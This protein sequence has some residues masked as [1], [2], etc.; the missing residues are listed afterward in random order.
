MQHRDEAAGIKDREP[1]PGQHY[2][3][4][5][6]AIPGNR[7]PGLLWKGIKRTAGSHPDKAAPG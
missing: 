5:R 1:T 3:N 4:T 7:G 2:H 6:T